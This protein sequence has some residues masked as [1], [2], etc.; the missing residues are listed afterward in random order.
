WAFLVL[1]GVASAGLPTR[2]QVT[3]DGTLAAA[4][5]QATLEPDGQGS[6][7]LKV[8]RPLLDA[9]GVEAGDTVTLALA[10]VAEEPEPTVPPDLRAALADNPAAR[11][12]WDDITAVARRDWIQ[13]VTSGKKAETRVKRI[14]TACDKLASG[15]R[16]ACC[17]DR[18]GMVSRGSLGPPAA[19]D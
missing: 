4:P 18:S 12:T 2:S 1:P 9:A 8:E 15:Q 13:W 11:D 6:H 3:V 10:P 5:F 7:W 14:A 17:F 16:R 19:A